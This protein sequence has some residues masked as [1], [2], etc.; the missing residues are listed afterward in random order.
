MRELF[1]K[2]KE[3]YLRD[4]VRLNDVLQTYWD[5]L[6]GDRLYPL[7]SEIDP[8]QIEDIWA[9]C[10]LIQLVPGGTYQYDYLGENLVAAYGE[11]L[12]QHELNNFVSADSSEAVSQFETV[13]RKKAPVYREGE[14]YNPQK[15]LIKYRQ[16]LLP[17]GGA[18]EKVTHILGG[19]RWEMF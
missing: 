7:E 12:C 11:P 15:L 9:D 19:V 8:S 18:D 16:L 4:Y 2:K 5:G 6:R 10:F 17:I 13:V 14:F 1:V 3:T